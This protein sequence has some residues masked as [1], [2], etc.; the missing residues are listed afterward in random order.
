MTERALDLR[1]GL[2]LAQPALASV[3]S[4]V[5]QQ[6]RSPP[7]LMGGAPSEATWDPRRL[8][9]RQDTADVRACGNVL[10]EGIHLDA[11][12]GRIGGKA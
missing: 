8:T 7:R 11:H 6:R 2:R 5:S 9:N 4:G 3:K 10:R 1:K 12:L